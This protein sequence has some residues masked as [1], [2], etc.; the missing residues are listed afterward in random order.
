MGVNQ[1]YNES[2]EFEPKTSDQQELVDDIKLTFWRNG[3]DH[4]TG[5]SILFDLSALGIFYQRNNPS[6]SEDSSE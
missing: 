4:E 3:I 6:E 1:F 2:Y 5:N